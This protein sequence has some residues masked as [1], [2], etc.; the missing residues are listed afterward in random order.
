MVLEN[1]PT[2]ELENYPAVQHLAAELHAMPSDERPYLL[3][4]YANIW[5]NRDE[6]NIV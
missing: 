2:Q 6:L 3:R 4:Q 5:R 1:S